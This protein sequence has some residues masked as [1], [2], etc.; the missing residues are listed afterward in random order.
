MSRSLIIHGAGGHGLVV[1]ESAAL[2]GFSVVGFVDDA[3]TQGFLSG[4]PILNMNLVGASGADIIVAIGDSAARQRV[5]RHHVNEGRTIVNVVHPKASVSPSAVI[6]KGVFVGP[7]AVINAEANIADGVIVNSR[8]IVEHHCS[9]GAFSHIAPGATLGGA[10][11]VGDLS[12]VGLGASVLPGVH[13]GSR[14]TVGAGAV[15]R[16]DVPDDTTVV[17]SPARPVKR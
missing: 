14:S 4:H 7:N 5:Q 8:A 12:L 3:I 15:V 9:V 6:G 10:A 1:A 2:S 17:G 11:T 16:E 13:V